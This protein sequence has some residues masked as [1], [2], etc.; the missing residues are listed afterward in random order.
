MSF[1]MKHKGCCDTVEGFLD[2]K[3]LD[4]NPY[5][6]HN[7]LCQFSGWIHLFWIMGDSY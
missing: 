7:S 1:T 2:Q 4:L 5:L 3:A 6:C